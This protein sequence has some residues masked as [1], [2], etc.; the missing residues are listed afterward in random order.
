VASGEVC[1]CILGDTDAAL[2][3]ATVASVAAVTPPPIEPL[4]VVPPGAQP[5]LSPDVAGRA[6]LHVASGA[7][8]GELIA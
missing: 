2:T 5:Q 6:R 7:R 1:V 8:T 4:V 3:A